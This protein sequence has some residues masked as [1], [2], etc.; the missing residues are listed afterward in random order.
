MTAEAGTGQIL[1]RALRPWVTWIG[2]GLLLAFVLNLIW[3]ALLS[4]SARPE[5]KEFVIPKGTAAV[6]AAGGVAP[7][8]PASFALREGA[9]IIVRNEDVV[10]HTV[11]N[12][13]IPP[14]ATGVI[15]PDPNSNELSCTIHPSGYLGIRITERPGLQ[16]TI[17]PTVLA[18]L[19]MGIT[20][21][22]VVV[23]GKK[24]DTHGPDA[25]L[26]GAAA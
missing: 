17:L 3:W 8:I 1:A 7:F 9:R 2:A 11:A 19:P 14:G 23:I 13:V 4:P 15:E 18:G 21:A 6:V 26:P 12:A 10:E 24:L 5:S 25:P 16:S 20:A 22:A